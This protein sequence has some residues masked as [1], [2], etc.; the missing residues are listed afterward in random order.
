M[1]SPDA[2]CKVIWLHTPEIHLK[3]FCTHIIVIFLRAN[4]SKAQRA[5]PNYKFF[6]S[7]RALNITY[8]I[9]IQ[10]IIR[11]H[12]GIQLFCCVRYLGCTPC[13]I[14]ICILAPQLDLRTVVPPTPLNV[15]IVKFMDIK[16]E[17]HQMS[18][19]VIP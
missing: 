3:F 11:W 2:D 6:G 18:R 4:T 17:M 13:S 1:L 14:P 15:L 12:V 10:S 5:S 9:F 7:L 19:H 16:R 8:S